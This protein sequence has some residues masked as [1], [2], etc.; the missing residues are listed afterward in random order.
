MNFD[1]QDKEIPHL[2]L[3]P[4]E[5]SGGYGHIIPQNYSVSK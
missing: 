3:L 5:Y 1:C 2:V 4:G